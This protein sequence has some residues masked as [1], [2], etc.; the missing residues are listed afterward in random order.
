LLSDSI[1]L[2]GTRRHHY[3]ILSSVFAAIIWLL[4]GVIPR[5]YWLLFVLLTMLNVMLVIGSTVVGA[6]I[7]EVGQSRDAAG[8]LVAVRNF[9]ESACGV[10]AG[11]F[12]GLLAIICR[13]LRRQ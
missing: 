12:G 13:F 11:T 4:L 1:P 6:L 9:I 2:F 8:R 3:L 7:V 5:S 10:I